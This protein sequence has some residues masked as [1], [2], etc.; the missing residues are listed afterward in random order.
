M[1]HNKFIKKK[2]PS[3]WQATFGVTAMIVALNIVALIYLSLIHI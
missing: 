2:F 3:I 1:E